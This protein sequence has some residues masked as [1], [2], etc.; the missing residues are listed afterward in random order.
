MNGKNDSILIPKGASPPPPS[1]TPR[2][3][4]IILDG[5]RRFA[6][7][8]MLKPWKG[9]EWGAQKFRA[10]V[11]WCNE[12]GVE[13]VT[14]YCL[15][16]QNFN[17]PK[18]EL[19]YIMAIFTAELQRLLQPEN[20]EEA[21]KQGVR[22][23]IIGRPQMLSLELQELCKKVMEATKHN[24]KKRVN[25]AF[26]YG[27]R[28]EIIDA[29]QK[30]AREVEGGRIK[31]EEINENTIKEHL[32]L[33]SDPDLIIRTGGEQRTSNF[34]PWQSTYSELMFVEKYWPELEKEDLIAYIKEYSERERRFGK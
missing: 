22:W 15:S 1:R 2:H 17:R 23:S 19:D 29:V 12:L 21:N 31:V 10:F 26:A 8:L 27:G 25:M 5:N 24:T 11:Q 32:W 6:K 20:L 30:I 14:A 28:E 13:E 18:E 34:L 3:I 4:G 16:V 33:K 9:H 7:R